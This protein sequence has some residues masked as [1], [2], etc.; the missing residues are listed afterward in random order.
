MH[1]CFKFKERYEEIHGSDGNLRSSELPSV[2]NRRQG[3]QVVE[4]SDDEDDSAPSRCQDTSTPAWKQE[5][6]KYL[7][8]RESIP[9]KITTI[10]WW[11]VCIILYFGLFPSLTF[12]YADERGD[13]SH[14][15]FDCP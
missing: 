14:L 10:K 5:F 15:G 13:L 8:V 3:N 7:G 6:S 9:D 12:S 1:T 11:A 4:L 2:T